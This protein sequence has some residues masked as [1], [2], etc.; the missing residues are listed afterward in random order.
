MRIGN[1]I[2][3]GGLL[4]GLIAAFGFSGCGGDSKKKDTGVDTGATADVPPADRP[5]ADVTPMTDVTAPAERMVDVTAPAERTSDVTAPAERMSDRGPDTTLL[6]D[7]T[8]PTL[9]GG[10]DAATDAAKTD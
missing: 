1:L 8:L 7:V 3:S 9:D 5:P 10:T 2:R 6:P 4:F